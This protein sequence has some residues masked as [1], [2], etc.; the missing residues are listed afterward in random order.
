MAGE[1]DLKFLLKSMNPLLHE[2]SYVFCTLENYSFIDP[3]DLVM[4]FNEKE[5]TTIIVRMETADKYSLKYDYIA[6]WITLTIHSSLDAVGLTA[7]FS[8][9]LANEGISCNVVA[10]FFHDHLFVNFKDAKKTMEI[11]QSIS[12]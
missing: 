4:T 12:E 6:A 5:G 7:T 11:L 1:K 10:G 8:T 9:A 2:G 3:K